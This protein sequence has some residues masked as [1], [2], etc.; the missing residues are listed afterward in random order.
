MT[1]DI[2][3]EEA[4]KGAVDLERWMLRAEKRRSGRSATACVAGG[5]PR[6]AMSTSRLWQRRKGGLCLLELLD[7]LME[8]RSTL[9]VNSGGQL[10]R[11]TWAARS[12]ATRVL[13]V[14]ALGGD[15]EG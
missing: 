6:L 5:A 9:A 10:W 2:L 3:W 12:A 8:L 14:R 11:P 7:R 4:L 1:A 15:A 13:F